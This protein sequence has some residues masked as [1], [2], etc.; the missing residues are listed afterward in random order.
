IADYT[1]DFYTALFAHPAVDGILS[2]GFWAGAHW[3]PDVAYLDDG[4]NPRPSDHALR[5]LIFEDWWTNASAPT[6]HAG[7]ATIRGFHGQHQVTIDAPG[8]G[9]LTRTIDLPA[10]GASIEIAYPASD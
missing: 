6:D 1:R 5:R 7:V 8:R 4:F 9:P 2:W 10:E 3:R